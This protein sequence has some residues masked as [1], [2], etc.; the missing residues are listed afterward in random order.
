MFKVRGIVTGEGIA[1]ALHREM[2]D[3]PVNNIIWDLSHASLSSLQPDELAA[4]ASCAKQF[5][6]MRSRPRTAI[7]VSS[8][9]DAVFMRLYEAVAVKTDLHTTFQI[10]N[11]LEE[12]FA[13]IAQGDTV[14]AG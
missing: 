12:A 13:W 14:A 6:P 5:E 11:S 1:E 2:S 4:I 9:V 10:V 7:I 3:E 8:S